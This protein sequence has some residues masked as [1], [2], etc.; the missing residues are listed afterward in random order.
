[1][2]HNTDVNMRNLIK[3][4]SHVTNSLLRVAGAAQAHSRAQAKL[5]FNYN[6]ITSTRPSGYLLLAH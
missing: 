4:W 3:C 2:N 6:H 1:M 5:S